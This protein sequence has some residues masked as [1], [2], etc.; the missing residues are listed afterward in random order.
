MKK[1][2]AGLMIAASLMFATACSSGGAATPTVTVT[3]PAPAP[4]ITESQDDKYLSAIRSRSAVLYSV[5]DATLLSLA[6]SIC[7]GLRGGIPIERVF[8]C[9]GADE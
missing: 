5:D 3:A 2:L 4:V 6:Q 8:Y 7:T 1:F 9:P